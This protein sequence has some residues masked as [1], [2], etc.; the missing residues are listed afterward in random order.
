[1]LKRAR[2]TLKM[3]KNRAAALGALLLA[4]GLGDAEGSNGEKPITFGARQAGRGGVDYGFA[5]DAIAAQTNPAGMAWTN[6]RIDFVSAFYL[7]EGTFSSVNQEALS[8]GWITAPLYQLGAVIDPTHDPNIEGMVEPGSWGLT[9]DSKADD[10]GGIFHFGFG[11]FTNSGENSSFPHIITPFYAPNALQYSGAIENISIAPSF[12]LRL[13]EDHFGIAYSPQLRYGTIAINS[14]IQQPGATSLLPAFQAAFPTVESYARTHNL[15]SW[16]FSQ[17]GGIM[18]RSEYL[19][20]GA[21]YQDRSYQQNYSGQI[22]FDASNGIAKFAQANPAAA[23]QLNTVLNPALGFVSKYNATVLGREEPRQVGAGVQV[24]PDS[25]LQFG[26]DYTWI[27]WSEFRS[28]LSVNLSNPRNPN[29]RV[30]TGNNFQINVPLNWS[31]QS[32][33]ALGIQGTV[34][35]GDE[36]VPNFP[37]YRLILRAGY[38]WGQSPIPKST[39]EPALPLIFEHH[40]TAGASLEIGPCYELTVA[41]T[42]AFVTTAHVGNNVANSDLS[43]SSLTMQD[44]AVL[45]QLSV[46]F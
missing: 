13:F 32:V 19:S 28:N 11:I 41:F 39:I 17:R 43:S 14:T 5:N 31:N 6:D 44:Y 46:K 27:M 26:I 22:D 35:E 20:V 45:T 34:L 30:L 29:L 36:I 38:N 12:A 25:R 18:F 4:F 1:V 21:V 16:G 8:P 23:A 40:V 15:E 3:T 9:K 24:S 2:L 37:S 7:P 10:P 33:V 42:H